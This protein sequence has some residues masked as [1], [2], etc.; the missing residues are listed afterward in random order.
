METSVT[1][2]EYLSAIARLP[3]PARDAARKAN[4]RKAHEKIWKRK[5][6]AWRIA[7]YRARKR[8][9]LKH[10]VNLDKNL[11][12]IENNSPSSTTK[13]PEPLIKK[14]VK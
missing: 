4:M 6:N 1:V 5:A 11:K 13:I 8:L 7:A 2:R 9:E 12:I 14:F 3:S 10:G